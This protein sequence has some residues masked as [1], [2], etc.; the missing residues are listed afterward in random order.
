M[1][2][3]SN[4]IKTNSDHRRSAREQLKGK[5]GSAILLCFL[6]SIMLTVAY[7]IF[8]LIP[9]IGQI[10]S[11]L[12]TGPLTLGVTICF[13]KLVRHKTFMIEN[14]FDGFKNFS[15]ALLAQLLMTIFVFLWTLLLIVPGIIAVYS[16]SLVFFI[17]CDNPE[18]GAMEALRRSKKMMKGFKWKLFCLHFSFIGWVLLS[19]LSLCIGYLWLMP[20]MYTAFA[21]FYENVKTSQLKENSSANYMEV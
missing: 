20:Y 7:G 8:S 21:N 9:V 4:L 17:L 15:S 19:I 18:L 10:I 2:L 3:E 13:L 6:F 1:Q 5:W 14:I 12:L 11:I 16:Y